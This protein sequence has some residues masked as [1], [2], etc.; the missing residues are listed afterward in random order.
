M[1]KLLYLALLL[2]P[3]LSY[4]GIED[5]ST[6]ASSNGTVYF[7]ENMSPADV[8][9]DAR[10]IMADIR[11]WYENVEFR[12]LG[13]TP[14]YASATTFTI[15]GDVTA[16]YVANQRIEAYGTTMGTLYGTISSSS[17]SAPNTTV[18]VSLDSGSLTANLSRVS[19]GIDPT[20]DPI[21]A[22]AVTGLGALSLKDTIDSASLLDSSVVTKAKIED[23]SD[24]TV[25]GNV[26][27]GAA[28]P[29]EVT[30]YDEDDMSTD[31]ATGLAT[32]QSIKSY[33]DSS[34]GKAIQTVYAEKTDTFSST[35]YDA[36]TDITDMSVTITAGASADKVCIDV[37]MYASKAGQSLTYYRILK[38]ASPL[39]VGDSAGSRIQATAAVYNAV[40]NDNLHPVPIYVCDD[41]PTT[42]A[43]T[44]K[45]Q[46]YTD[47]N[48]NFFVNRTGEDTDST[49]YVR[50]VSTITATEFR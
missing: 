36:W 18:T 43:T 31:S 41:S 5:Y 9:N 26:S 28:A 24:Y 25:L 3:T 21:P 47:S 34:S 2:V 15:S 20:N 38:G 14:T 44:Y 42:S 6:T 48:Q 46:F 29:A 17:Y 30:I 33:V 23:L 45:V 37:N 35:T 13:D 16:S 32:Q 11:A 39:V 22:Q 40:G 50:T 49:A 12:D 1:K 27:G 7:E 4:A 19:V 8:N 10:S